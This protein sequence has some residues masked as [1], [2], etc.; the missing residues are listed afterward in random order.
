[1]C[2][3]RQFK[4][5]RLKVNHAAGVSPLRLAQEFVNGRANFLYAADIAHHLFL[6]T[7]FDLSA[8][9]IETILL[10]EQVVALLKGHAASEHFRFQPLPELSVRHT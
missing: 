1:M 9:V 6:I 4:S 10:F 3:S 8:V 2:G 7:P 5:N